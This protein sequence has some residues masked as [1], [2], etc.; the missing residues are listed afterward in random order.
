MNHADAEWMIIKAGKSALDIAG[1]KFHNSASA[2][3]ISRLRHKHVHM[4]QENSPRRSAKAEPK[5]SS[6]LPFGVAVKEH[7]KKLF[8]V[9]RPNPPQSFAA[10]PLD[11]NLFH[12]WRAR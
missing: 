11:E 8:L 2:V 9:F 12:Y 5:E 6:P 3:Q 10:V 4:G 7:S 1:P